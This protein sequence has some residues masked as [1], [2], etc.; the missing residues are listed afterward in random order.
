MKNMHNFNS[1][2]LRFCEIMIR[3]AIIGLEAQKTCP[4]VFYLSEGKKVA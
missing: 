4:Q 3:Y 2:R 1:L